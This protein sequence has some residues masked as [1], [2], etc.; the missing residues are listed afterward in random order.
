M[1][2]SRSRRV[3][4]QM[5]VLVESLQ[6]LRSDVRAVRLAIETGV[7]AHARHVA[8]GKEEQERSSWKCMFCGKPDGECGGHTVCYKCAE[9]MQHL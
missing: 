6:A 8:R 1:N 7:A 3:D 9:G 5:A 2:T 4:E